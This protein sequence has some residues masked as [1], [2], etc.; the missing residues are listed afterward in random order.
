MRLSVHDKGFID[1][2]TEVYLDGERVE[3]CTE[4]DEELGVVVVLARNEDGTFKLKGDE[5]ET[6]I[7]RGTVRIQ[8]PRTS[9]QKE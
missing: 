3:F 8:V 1:P 2:R 5:V 6:I 9:P 7:K 4:A